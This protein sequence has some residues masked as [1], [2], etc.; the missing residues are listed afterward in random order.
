M[1]CLSKSHPAEE[2]VMMFASQ[3]GK[4]EVG[5]NLVGYTI[6]YDPGPMLA[7][8]PTVQTAKR[9]S[10]QRLS[11]LISSTDR[12][13]DK[14]GGNRSRASQNTLFEKE[15]PGG[16]MIIGGANSA[17]SL[18]SM[19]I[20]TVILDE[21]DRFPDDVDDEGDPIDLAEKRASNFPHSKILKVSTPTV[22]GASKIEDAYEA[23]DMRVLELPCPHCGVYQELIWDQL[24]FPDGPESAHYLCEH[25]D[26]SIEEHQKRWMLDRHQWTPTNP[27]APKGRVGFT[28]NALCAPLGWVS[29]VKLAQEWVEAQDNP[30]KL[31]VFINTR[32][33]QTW[34][35]RG[36]QPDWEKVYLRKESYEQGVVPE[37][38]VILT[39]GV[40]VQK[41]RLELEVVGWGPGLESWSVDYEVIH[42]D[43]SSDGVWEELD[44]L[45]HRN[46]SHESGGKLDISRVFIDSG[47]RAQ[48]VYSFCRDYHWLEVTPI[49]GR[50]SQ[51]M[52]IS[53]PTDVEKTSTGKRVK[54]GVKLVHVGTDLLKRELYGWLLS[55]LPDEGEDY[56]SGWCHFPDYGQEYFKQLC[57][58]KEVART[59]KGRTIYEFE[60]QRDRNEALDCRVYARAAAVAEG[61]DRWSEDRWDKMRDRIEQSGPT[62]RERKG[63]R[64]RKSDRRRKRG[65][66]GRRSR[67]KSDWMD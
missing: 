41:D 27:D 33:A 12:V 2:V 47:Y 3:L 52:P 35:I 36:E 38:A 65:G 57:A 11:S 55:S 10:K 29:W 8:Q 6:D 17:A 5:I 44:D 50:Q 63:R 56:P 61:I 24:K 37:G 19:P 49:K 51:P 54:S 21:V 22:D 7:V 34:E 26:E 4:T 31:R 46:W 42:G 40:D 48:K 66:S 13:S 16:M 58:E 1:Q 28:M 9:F 32:L 30:F 60:P 45:I 59:R 53:R 25:C 62:A 20:E 18:A 14:L 67:R 23:S 15:F 39:A 43:T 64:E